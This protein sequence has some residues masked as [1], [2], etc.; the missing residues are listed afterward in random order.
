MITVK[1]LQQ[2]IQNQ[3]KAS[4][5]LND[6]NTEGSNVYRPRDA[7]FDLYLVKERLQY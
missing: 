5:K 7:H 3:L 6:A 1:D 2:I 4:C